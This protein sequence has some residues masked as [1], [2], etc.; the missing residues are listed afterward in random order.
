MG[1]FRFEV[2]HFCQKNKE[3]AGVGQG[4]QAFT[5]SWGREGGAARAALT[6]SLA[7]LGVWMSGLKP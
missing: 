1:L 5:V 4:A 6:I 2:S 3:L 7:F